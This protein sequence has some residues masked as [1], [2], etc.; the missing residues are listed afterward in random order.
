MGLN[1]LLD[2][3]LGGVSV[4]PETKAWPGDPYCINLQI[5]LLSARDPPGN[6]RPGINPH[7]QAVSY[8]H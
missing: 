4:W 2:T 6:V 5:K 3:N 8:G 1:L 7:A